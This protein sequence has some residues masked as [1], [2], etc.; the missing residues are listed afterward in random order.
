MDLLTIAIALVSLAGMFFLRLVASEI[1]DWL[2]W[3]ARRIIDRTVA[4]LPEQERERYREEWYSHLDECPGRLGKIF[5]AVGCVYGARAVAVTVNHPAREKVTR[6]TPA[7][8]SNRIAG[9]SQKS[10]EA[11]ADLFA[12]CLFHKTDDLLRLPHFDLDKF[13]YV[14]RDKLGR[15][16]L[17]E[18]KRSSQFDYSEAL[19]RL[20]QLYPGA[21]IRR[22]VGKK[23]GSN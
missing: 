14:M 1:Q 9:S 12:H 23:P 2:P 16:T 17:I 7:A 4:N 6:P 11:Q 20:D 18:F 19:R 8:E 21:D 5:H 10:P 3:L 15:V 22:L 13:D